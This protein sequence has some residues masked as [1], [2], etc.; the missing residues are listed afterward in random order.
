MSLEHPLA[1][2]EPRI[3]RTDSTAGTDVPAVELSGITKAFPGVLAND[4]ISLR[5]MAGEVLCLL[6]ENGAGKSTLMSILSG[7]YQPDEGSIR[8][9]G[10]EVR[11]DSPREGRQLGIGM[12]Y[13]HLSLI[14]TLS[15][16]E[17]LMLGSEPRP[18]LDEAAARRRFD[19]LSATL[20]VRIDPSVRVGALALGQ[21]QYVEIIKALWKGSRVL[22]LDEP[23]SMLTPQG[24]E[25]LQKVLLGLKAT[26][27]AIIFI[28]H[29]LHEAIAIGDRVT[30]LKAGRVVGS[31]GPDDI[32]GVDAA[33]LQRTIVGIMFGDD[34]DAVG[35]IAELREDLGTGVGGR[36][37]GEAPAVEAGPVILELEGVSAPGNRGQHSLQDA[38]FRLSAG[39]I[40][41]VAGMDGSGQHALAEVIAGQRRASA[42]SIRLDGQPID[43]ATVGQRQRLG[44]RSVT[45]DRLGEGVVAR[46]PV[47]L[48]LVLKR[49][50]DAP[51]WR[52]GTLDR[53]AI[54]ANA[55][56]LVERFDI[57]TPSVATPIGKLSGGNIQKALLARELSFDPKVV[58]FNKPTHGLDVRTIGVVRERIRALAARGVGVIVI[59]TDLDELLDLSG[60]IA[61]LSRGRIAGIVPN[62]PE[63]ATRIGE[64]VIGDDAPDGSVAPAGAPDGRPSRPAA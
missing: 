3:A 17:N 64:L 24:I 26:G 52:R 19:D 55:R 11:I 18:V 8:V 60:R 20:A 43:T 22:I 21:Q 49:I 29:K 30:I 59:S 12:V 27:L 61:V 50:G 33:A 41:G 45:D 2:S 51:F 23:T 42:G 36:G 6:G 63:A 39:E 56:D 1:R 13:Q 4:H 57:R 16:L 58:V 47:S 46:Y 37:S 32:R 34:T 9:Q 31:L 53:S 5:V 7:L 10:R 38:S 28:T 62:G 40:L 54:D 15:V 14:P 44:L 25:E 35:A 48:N